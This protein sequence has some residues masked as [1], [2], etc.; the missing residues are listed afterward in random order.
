MKFVEGYRIVIRNKNG[1]NLT[2]AL[3][4]PVLSCALDSEHLF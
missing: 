2:K 3:V 1:K 4:K